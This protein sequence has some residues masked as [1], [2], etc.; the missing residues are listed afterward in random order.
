MFKKLDISTVL[1]TEAVENIINQSSS[2]KGY[3]PNKDDNGL[4]YFNSSEEITEFVKH[5]LP[6][7][8]RELGRVSLC[9][10][11]GGAVP[12]RDHD[13]KC[14]INFYL[15]SGDAKTF[16]FSDPDIP[17]YSYNNDNQHNIYS[18]KEH[19]LKRTCD[20][21]AKDGDII[22]LDTSQIHAVSLPQGNTRIIVSISFDI[23][24]EDLLSYF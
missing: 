8:L 20:F 9:K 21:V 11:I 18:L 7:G 14:K 3:S 2:F 15:R 5:A 6:A 24:Y 17:G 16:F 23:L 12:H 4:F 10:I 13:C 22:A 1:N 19:R